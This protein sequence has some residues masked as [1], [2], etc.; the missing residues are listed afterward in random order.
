M[1]C[2]LLWHG[3]QPYLPCLRSGL[4]AWPLLPGGQYGASTLS[5]W[6][7]LAGAWGGNKRQLHSLHSWIL[8][9]HIW[10]RQSKLY[11]MRPWHVQQ[12]TARDKLFLVRARW[13]LRQRW[14]RKCEH[15]L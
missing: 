13:V 5:Y 4:L 12:R 15:D 10:Q 11:A 9:G 1:L 8:L 3:T 7:L 2:W 6:H 14:S